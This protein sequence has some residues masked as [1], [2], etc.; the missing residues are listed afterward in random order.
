MGKSELTNLSK[1]K[2]EEVRGIVLARVL[3]RKRKVRDLLEEIKDDDGVSL[4]I[5]N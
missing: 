3:K 1:S 2:R 5:M 4:D